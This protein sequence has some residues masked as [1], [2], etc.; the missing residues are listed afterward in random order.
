MSD[1]R[2]K[3]GNGQDGAGATQEAARLECF[4]VM[5]ISD[6]DGYQAGHFQHV[7]DDVFAP[8]CNRAGFRPVRADQVRETN[9]IHLDV[10]QRL[11]VSPMVLC[12][13]SS[14][15]P[16][17]LFE[18]GLRQA[19]DKPVVLVQELGTPKIFDIAPLRYTEY[20]KARVYH[21]VLEDQKAIASA[22]EATR[23]AYDKGT[24]INSIVKILSLTQPARLV[25]VQEANRDPAL[26]IIRAELS[27][28]RLEFRHVMQ[29]A[30]QPHRRVEDDD[31][32]RFELNR[33]THQIAEIEQRVAF[34]KASSQ[35]DPEILDLISRA[36]NRL[37]HL[38]GRERTVRFRHR[39]QELTHTLRHVEREYLAAAAQ[40]SAP[41]AE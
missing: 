35:T 34:M 33:L 21:E 10:L 26:Q 36:Q 25:D 5:P 4:V 31:G 29:R 2:M 14:R 19:F 8:A 38:V 15:N 37:D 30:S 7:F 24:G 28:L 40:P 22:I 39:F 16:N 3:T 12:D 17:V 23:D 20:R 1:E 27:E 41:N 11:L 32:S 9:L 13:L 6:P 18:L